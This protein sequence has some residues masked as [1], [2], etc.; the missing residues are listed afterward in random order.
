M[1][2]SQAELGSQFTSCC[3]HCYLPCTVL[4]HVCTAAQQGW[5]FHPWLSLAMSS[6]DCLRAACRH[7][8]AAAQ[9]KHIQAGSWGGKREICSR[10]LMQGGFSCASVG[11]K[12]MWVTCWQKGNFIGVIL[13]RQKTN[14]ILAVS[15][16]FCFTVLA[17]GSWKCWKEY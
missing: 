6:S 14:P 4:A 7:I 9:T 5:M 13:T 1:S 11:V 16:C 10:A 12:G 15:C 8:K 3:G 17:N 2:S